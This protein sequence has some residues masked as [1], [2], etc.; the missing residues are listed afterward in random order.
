[1]KEIVKVGGR[2]T[3]LYSLTAERPKTGITLIVIPGNPGAIDFYSEFITELFHLLDQNYSIVGIGHAGHLRQPNAHEGVY[4]LEEQIQHKID[5][6]ESYG[7]SRFVMMGHSVGAYISLQVAKR[8]PDLPILKI[9]NLFPT[10]RDLYQ[11]LP[12]PVKVVMRPGLRQLLGVVLHFIP[13][14]VKRVLLSLVRSNFDQA[15]VDLVS[16][17]LNYSTIQNILYMAY[18]EAYQIVEL[19]E[20]LLDHGER[21]VQPKLLFLYGRTDPY[22]PMKFHDDMKMRLPEGHVHLA[23]EEVPHAFVLKHSSPIARRVAVF[24]EDLLEREN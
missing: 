24:L 6:L 13:S 20:S 23:D 7:E 18:N 1:M 16:C 14:S 15:T 17:L 2:P 22:T 19:D 5:F 11:G 8:R 10:V 12:G 3:E 9:I 21:K 4:S